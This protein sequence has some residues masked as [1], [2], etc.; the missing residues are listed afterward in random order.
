MNRA[1]SMDALPEPLA[2]LVREHDYVADVIADARI[3]MQEGLRA[4]LDAQRSAQMLKVMRDLE[5]F[6][7]SHLTV[8]IA[9]EEDILFPALVRD[10]RQLIDDMVGQHDHIRER[11]ALLAR[12]MAALDAHDGPIDQA[13]EA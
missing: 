3:A 2:G 9:K 1:S 10:V 8:H 11:Q 5:L 7:A 4:P 6:L 13:R 12:A